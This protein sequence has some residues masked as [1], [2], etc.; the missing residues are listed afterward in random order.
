MTCL[1][2][3]KK[4]VSQ[5]SEP[6]KTFQGFST[7]DPI[8]SNFMKSQAKNNCDIR[9]EA[10]KRMCLQRNEASKLKFG[11]GEWLTVQQVTSYFSGLA[12]MKKLGQ[13]PAAVESIE[14]DDIETVVQQ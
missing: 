13:L 12:V 11:K 14:E 10:A 4:D 3:L 9:T 6:A 1:T 2:A 8:N 5:R 7:S